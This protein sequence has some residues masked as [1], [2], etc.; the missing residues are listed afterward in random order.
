[1]RVAVGVTVTFNTIIYEEFKMKTN[2][3]LDTDSYKLSHFMMLPEGTEY[4]FS[5]VE[6]RGGVHDT[7]LFFGLQALLKYLNENFPTLDDLEEAKAFAAAHGELF[8]EE[9]WKQVIELGYFPLAVKAVAEG[10]VSRT[11]NLL[12]G[13]VNTIPGLGWLVGQLEPLILSGVWYPTTVATQS[14]EAK[15]VIRRYMEATSDSLDGLEFKLHDFGRRGVSSSMSGGIGGAAHLVNFQGTDT[16]IAVR[17][18]MHYYNSGVCGYSIPASEHSVISAWGRDGEEAAYENILDK[19]P[20][21]PV[22][23]VS[24]IY[25]IY[26]AVDQIWGQN[27]RMKVLERDG[28]LVIRPDSGDPLEVI[29]RLL[30][31]MGNRFGYHKNGKGYKVLNDKVRLIQGDGVDLP[32]IEAILSKMAAMGWS[33]DNIAFGMGGGLLQ[34]V[35]RD[36]QKFAMKASAVCINGEWMDVYKDPITDSGKRSKRGVLDVVNGQTVKVSI[37]DFMNSSATDTRM[38]YLNGQL[39]IDDTFESIRQRAN[40]AA[41]EISAAA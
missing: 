30:E 15:K 21:G 14:F 24:D 31:S 37:D 22:A 12:V 33:A 39:L 3:I 28:V 17:T 19:F 26:Q 38:V 32:A 7:V 10:S 1:M 16:M 20:S 40:A 29:P 4:V 9:G 35:N 34:D 36:T 8:N 6:S 18:A 41:E 27:L 2:I 11:K 25:N 13:I 5:Y 23:C